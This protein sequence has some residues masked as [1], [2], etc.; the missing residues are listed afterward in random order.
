MEILQDLSVDFSQ[1]VKKHIKGLKK[2]S[3]KE[4]KAFG[5]LFADFK[6]GLDDMST[7]ESV[8]EAKYNYK[9]DA[10]DAYMKG[11]IT[12]KELD[13]IA[14]KDFKSSV[15]TKKELQSF[16]DSGYMKQLMANTYG[17]KVPAMEK[18]V[19][20]LMRFAEGTLKEEIESL[21]EAK[22]HISKDEF[23]ARKAGAIYNNANAIVDRVIDDKA[24][25]K[26]VVSIMGPILINA[27][28]A[29]IKHKFKPM[30][31]K[32]AD[33]KKFQSKLKELLKHTEALVKK[34]SKAGVKRLEV[35]HRE[36][37]N[38]NFGAAIVLN[39]EF[40]DSIVELNEAE[41]PEIITQLRKGGYQTIKD[42][43]TGKKH[44]VD[45]YSSSAIVAVYDALKKD[46][47]KEK[48]VNLPLPKMVNVA[49]K[50][51]K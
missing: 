49:F 30:P 12:A 50:A 47:V 21:N 24:D 34:P 5:K 9:Q 16:L 51:M 26:E 33:L 44:K 41:E 2:L 35:M 8:N 20:E 39:G 19:K 38:F 32:E 42:P 13:Q 31:G 6:E 48:F 45:N 36:W 28:K 27:I 40:M 1:L 7:N 11:K 4:Q 25:A 18:K 15:A 23:G 14:K 3:S 46:K 37:W 17:L 10:M 22:Y 43:Q 29:T